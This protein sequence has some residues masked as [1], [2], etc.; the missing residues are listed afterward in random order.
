MFNANNLHSLH[1]F[2]VEGMPAVLPGQ[3]TATLPSISTHQLHFYDSGV[4][5]SQWG[6][7]FS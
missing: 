7:V 6:F 1:L 5:F 3:T 4:A 2:V